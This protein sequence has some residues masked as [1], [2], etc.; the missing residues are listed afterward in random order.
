VQAELARDLVANARAA[1]RHQRHLARQDAR[2]EGRRGRAAGH[3]YADSDLSVCLPVC[4]SLVVGL[5]RCVMA[6]GLSGPL[7]WPGCGCVCGWVRGRPESA[8]RHVCASC[9]RTAADYTTRGGEGL[10][11]TCVA[12]HKQF[13]DESETVKQRTKERRGSSSGRGVR[14]MRH[15]K[16]AG[17][18][19]TSRL[20]RTWAMCGDGGWDTTHQRF[21]RRRRRRRGPG[22]AR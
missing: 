8:T 6:H 3:R 15:S 9:G 4:L 2:P 12:T 5:V 11:H 18:T 1:P 14:L 13:L 19:L 7:P 17:R 16:K 20:H 21:R 22:T 10:K